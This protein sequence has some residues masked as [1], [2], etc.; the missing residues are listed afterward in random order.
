MMLGRKWSGE[1]EF[2]MVKISARRDLPDLPPVN[3]TS[4]FS[5]KS[6]NPENDGHENKQIQRSADHWFPAAG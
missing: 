4:Y 5:K 6:I 2:L 1:K 3:R